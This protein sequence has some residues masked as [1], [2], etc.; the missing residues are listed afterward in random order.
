MEDIYAD[1]RDIYHRLKWGRWYWAWSALCIVG[2]V[3]LGLLSITV[4]MCWHPVMNW[5]V[6][7]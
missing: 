4:A 7:P 2:W 6:G 5:P 3:L 1:S